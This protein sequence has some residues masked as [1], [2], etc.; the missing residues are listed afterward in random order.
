MRDGF[1]EFIEE[2]RSTSDLV[3]LIGAEVE[4]HRSG[5]CYK[6]RSPDIDG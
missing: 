1:R 2:L 6:G 3:E 4:L 5:S